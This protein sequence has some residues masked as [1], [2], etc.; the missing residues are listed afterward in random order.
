M[1]PTTVDERASPC[2]PT[3]RA[4]MQSP[5]TTPPAVPPVTN[6]SADVRK[7]LPRPFSPR[8]V[9]QASIDSP[10]GDQ[11]DRTADTTATK[12][13]LGTTQLFIEFPCSPVVRFRG[14]SAKR[15]TLGTVRRRR[16][17]RRPG[18]PTNTPIVGCKV[19]C[20]R[21]GYWLVAQDGGIFSFGAPFLG[22]PA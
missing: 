14:S 18:Q 22:S 21:S 12:A 7:R 2:T 13:A 8:G 15:E 3:A 17:C 10:H 5:N 6:H 20:P 19:P 1:T 16:R 9:M 4:A 11:V